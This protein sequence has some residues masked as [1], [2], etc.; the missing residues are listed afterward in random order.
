MWKQYSK[1][2]VCVLPCV[3]A[4]P[5]PPP[6]H[7]LAHCFSGFKWPPPCTGFVASGSSADVLSVVSL[8]NNEVSD[9]GRLLA[10]RWVCRRARSLFWCNTQIRSLRQAHSVHFTRTHSRHSAD[11]R[12]EGAGEGRR[13]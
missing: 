9:L 4:V 5:S 3:C 10:V 7:L 13:R 6:P 8:A 12:H 1:Q 2:G 11:V